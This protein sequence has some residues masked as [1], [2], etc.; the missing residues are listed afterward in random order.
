M[1]LAAPDEVSV[2][3]VDI[4]ISVCT[5]DIDLSAGCDDRD[6]TGAA[7]DPGHGFSLEPC[8]CNVPYF[9]CSLNTDQHV[10]QVTES[11]GSFWLV[12]NKAYEVMQQI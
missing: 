8:L 12:L 6:A 7:P 2:C 3:T 1:V 11:F 5:V 9:C 4:D 10:G